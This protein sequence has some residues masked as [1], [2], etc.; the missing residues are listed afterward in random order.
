MARVEIFNRKNSQ[1][2]TARRILL[3]GTTIEEVRKFSP[4]RPRR[5]LLDT[6][7]NLLSYQTASYIPYSSEITLPRSFPAE[8]EPLTF[9]EKRLA[10][11]RKSEQTLKEAGIEF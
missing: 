3:E 9:E 5:P 7:F 6:L 1:I 10:L 8:E 2:Q 11:I 4:P